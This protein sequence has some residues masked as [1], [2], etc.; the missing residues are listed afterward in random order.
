MPMR[1]LKERIKP[2]EL[3]VSKFKL[4]VAIVAALLASSCV[5][6]FAIAGFQ[7][8]KADEGQPQYACVNLDLG[9]CVWLP[10]SFGK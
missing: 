9:D 1:T 2:K 7:V 8:R 10:K 4:K 6:A 3:T 5:T